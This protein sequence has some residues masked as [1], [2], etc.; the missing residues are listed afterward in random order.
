MEIKKK[1]L[2]FL[3]RNLVLEKSIINKIKESINTLTKEQLEWIYS[4]LV[5]LD[6]KQTQVLEK[7][8]KNTPW[9]F[10][11]MEISVWKD[12]YEK[13]IKEEK[14]KKKYIEEFLKNQLF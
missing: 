13:H 14:K 3:N 5:E 6:N 11:E 9:F 8:L 2:E 4:I 10:T 12:I 7:R 1:I